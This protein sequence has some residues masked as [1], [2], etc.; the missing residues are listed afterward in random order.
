MVAPVKKGVPYTVQ[1]GGVNDAG[2]PLQ[3]LFDYL[4]TPPHRLTAS[5]TL[6]ALGQTAGI[7][8]VGLSVT[9]A[10]AASVTV[11][12]GSHCHPITKTGSATETFPH[13]K[14]TVMPSGSK[15]KI[16]V[17][18]PKSIGVY[19]EYDMGV[20]NF[21]KVTRCLEPGSKRPRTKCS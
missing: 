3:V 5:S 7:K 8:L 20:A 16:Y 6:S 2:G 9:A 19:I 21:T 13:L 11:N 1:I 17:T 15:L 10:R 12:C 4:V 18:A 14:G